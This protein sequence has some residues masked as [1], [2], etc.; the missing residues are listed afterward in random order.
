MGP[1]ET[2]M[3]Q[4]RARQAYERGRWQRAW[5]R[6]AVAPVVVAAGLLCGASLAL[7]VSC[8][9]LLAGAVALG[10]W[11]GQTYGRAVRAGLLAGIAPLVMP[12]LL[13]PLGHSIGWTAA[14]WQMCVLAC[15]VPGFFAGIALGARAAGESQRLRYLATAAAVTVLAGA[16][17]CAWAGLMGVGGM[18]AGVLVGGTPL[19]V[20]AVARR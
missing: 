9:V 3:L 10:E 12:T 1:A 5:H 15:T 2:V 17:G 16:P 4:E 20:L 14:C 13:G 11:R 8:G 7:A 19:L 6:A 18:A